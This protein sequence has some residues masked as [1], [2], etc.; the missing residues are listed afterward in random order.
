MT[1]AFG[2]TLPS[3]DAAATRPAATRDRFTV[4]LSGK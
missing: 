3:P 2:S 1:L 4:G